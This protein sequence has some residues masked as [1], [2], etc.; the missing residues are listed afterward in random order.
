MSVPFSERTLREVERTRSNCES[1]MD[2]V[3]EV[4]RQ[5]EAIEAAPHAEDC[6]ITVC[7]C[8]CHGCANGFCGNHREDVPHVHM[9][10]DCWKVAALRQGMQAHP[11]AGKDSD[12]GG[13]S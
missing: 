8:R 7:L 11:A 3:G 2:L 1:C 6:S 10:C 9:A 13:K 12:G 4:R 5:R